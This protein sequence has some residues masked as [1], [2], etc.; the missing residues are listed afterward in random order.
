MRACVCVVSLLA[1]LLDV[2]SPI[3]QEARRVITGMGAYKN[4]GM[5]SAGNLDN[6]KTQEMK[7]RS[8]ISA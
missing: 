7:I 3:S 8:E 1:I 2:V 5:R 6:L 4:E